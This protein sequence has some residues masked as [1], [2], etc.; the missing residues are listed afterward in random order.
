MAARNPVF[1]LTLSSKGME[2]THTDSTEFIFFCG[3]DTYDCD[4]RV[5]EF[6]SPKIYNI[7]EDNPSINCYRLNTLDKHSRLGELLRIMDNGSIPVFENDIDFFVGISQEFANIELQEQLNNFLAVM[8]PGNVLYKFRLKR[9]DPIENQ[10]NCEEM[11]FIVSH[12]DEINH[13]NLSRAELNLISEHPDLSFNTADAVRRAIENYLP[14]FRPS[15]ENSRCPVVILIDREN[16]P[17]RNS[18]LGNGD[19]LPEPASEEAVAEESEF[20]AVQYEYGDFDPV[21]L[22]SIPDVD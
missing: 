1:V 13:W 4:S 12:F 18:T 11:N 15:G 20:N 16:F 2:H 10:S 17:V 3:A 6:L 7:R 22:S 9:N 8:T 19:P 5:A 14:T 21:D